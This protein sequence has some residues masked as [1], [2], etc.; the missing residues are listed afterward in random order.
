MLQLLG[1]ATTSGGRFEVM[2]SLLGQDVYRA[3]GREG[4]EIPGGRQRTRRKE[5][6]HLLKS[7]HSV[8]SLSCWEKA[9][10]KLAS[11]P[12]VKGK[13]AALL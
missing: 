1:I 10:L 8:G 13:R 3:C 5:G 2:K 4:E 7:H 9:C 11:R 12:P 6:L